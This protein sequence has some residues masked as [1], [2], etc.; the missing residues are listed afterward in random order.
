MREFDLDE[1][2]KEQEEASAWLHKLWLEKDLMKEKALKED[3]EGLEK[4]GIKPFEGEGVGRV[5]ALQ[6]WL[7]LSIFCPTNCSWTGLFLRALGVS[8]TERSLMC[9]SSSPFSTS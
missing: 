3:W 9:S 6:R 1:V 7:D 5:M 4:V 8:T 2:P